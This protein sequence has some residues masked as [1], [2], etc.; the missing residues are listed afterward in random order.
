MPA[1][2]KPPESLLDFCDKL[3]PCLVR[4]MAMTDRSDET[5]AMR[6]RLMT[7]EEIARR[8]GL[9][10]R[11]VQ[12]VASATS[13]KW[14]KLSTASK[15]IAGCG[16]DMVN[17]EWLAGFLTKYADNNF[18]YMTRKQRNYFFGLMNWRV[19]DEK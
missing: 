12:R 11:T 5:R 9:P 19:E 13:W 17:R 10:Y 1:K 4:A 8:S 15:F 18:S 16:V 3:P 7:V 2:P 6:Y 14:I